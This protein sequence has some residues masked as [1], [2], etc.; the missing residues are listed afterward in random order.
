M[1]YFRKN[2][3]TSVYRMIRKT[4]HPSIKYGSEPNSH[5][6]HRMVATGTNDGVLSTSPIPTFT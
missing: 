3:H 2:N 5:P 1:C 4:I 6:L